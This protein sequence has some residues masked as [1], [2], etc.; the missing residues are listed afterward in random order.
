MHNEH[1]YPI[2]TIRKLLELADRFLTY[3]AN[4]EHFRVP[5]NEMALAALKKIIR[6]MK[7]HHNPAKNEA[8]IKVAIDSYNS[9]LVVDEK[10]PLLVPLATD[11]ELKKGRKEK[12]PML[13]ELMIEAPNQKVSPINLLVIAAFYKQLIQNGQILQL[14]DLKVNAAWHILL[15]QLRNIHTIFSREDLT[16]SADGAPAL[17]KLNDESVRKLLAEFIGQ[18]CIIGHEESACVIHNYI[19]IAV[20]TLSGQR[21]YGMTEESAGSMI[22]NVLLAGLELSGALVLPEGDTTELKYQAAAAEH[23]FFPKLTPIFISDP[24]FQKPFDKNLYTGY[25]QNKALY[26]AT[27]SASIKLLWRDVPRLNV[28]LSD[29]IFQSPRE[30]D[31]ESPKEGSAPLVTPSSPEGVSLDLRSRD[32]QDRKDKQPGVLIKLFQKLSVSDKKLPSPLTPKE[33]AAAG[34]PKRTSERT[35]SPNRTVTM[36]PRPILLGRSP[37]AARNLRPQIVSSTGTND[38]EDSEQQYSSGSPITPRYT[39]KTKP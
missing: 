24:L 9:Q 5:G 2:R 13:T 39:T 28:P 6:K 37:S 34:S 7:W 33:G 14:T 11:S 1:L 17:L 8:A 29:V 10:I 16:K 3:D 21:S 19:H 38:A 27:L 18:L 15:H 12:E 35:E 36:S 25:Q 20:K 30:E 31:K 4:D 32:S 26:D 22:L 23:R